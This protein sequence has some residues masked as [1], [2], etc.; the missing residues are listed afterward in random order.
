M[1]SS[2]RKGGTPGFN[3]AGPRRARRGIPVTQ[4]ERIPATLQ[5]GR[6]TEGPERE[7]YGLLYAYANTLQWGRATEGPERRISSLRRHSCGCFNGAGPRRARR[8]V[9]KVAGHLD[10]SASMGPGHGGPG[11][12]AQLFLWERGQYEASMGPG[13]GGPGEANFAAFN[14][15]RCGEASMGPGHGGPGEAI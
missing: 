14:T 7:G 11:E 15:P 5:W 6:A 2:S 3:G 12:K 10:G 1:S 9:G 8:G 4:Q 13:H